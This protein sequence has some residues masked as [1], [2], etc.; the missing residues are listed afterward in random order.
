[1]A[2]SKQIRSYKNPPQPGNPRATEAWALSQAAL[3]LKDA[4]LSGDK[5]SLR[6][7]VRLNWRLWTIFQSELLAPQCQ[8][9][10]EMRLN[11]LSLANFVDKHSVATIADPTPDKADVLIGINRELASGL[12]TTPREATEATSAGSTATPTPVS[13]TTEGLAPPPKSASETAAVRMT[14]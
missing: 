10:Q 11:M 2:N 13:G 6:T 9:P 5:E 12:F 4:A 1:M 8:V 7:A 14:T 3:R